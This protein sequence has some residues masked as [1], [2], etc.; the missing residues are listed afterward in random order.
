MNST[1]K[2]ILVVDDDHSIRTVL[3]EA[4]IDDGYEVKI[5]A[6]GEKA[7]AFA[8]EERFDLVIA[9]LVMPRLNGIELMER[10]REEN[11]GIGF[12]IITASDA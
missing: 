2:K 6:D 5:A 1:E 7:L 9:D 12:L 10:I 3:K 4:L 8:T 11:P